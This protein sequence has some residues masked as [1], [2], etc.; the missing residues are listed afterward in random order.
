MFENKAAITGKKLDLLLS[1]TDGDVLIGVYDYAARTSL[2][3]PLMDFW[4]GNSFTYIV[5]AALSGIVALSAGAENQIPKNTEKALERVRAKYNPTV[6]QD[7]SAY[8]QDTL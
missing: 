3:L 4:P 8:Y 2:L 5:I 7:T 1:G 6:Q